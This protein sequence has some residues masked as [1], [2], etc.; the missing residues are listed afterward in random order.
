[1][2]DPEQVADR[3]IGH[4]R[5]LID[6]DPE[7]LRQDIVLRL[8]QEQERIDAA[9]SPEDYAQLVAR[10]ALI[11]GLR[12]TAQEQARRDDMAE[13][14][15]RARRMRGRMARGELSCLTQDMGGVDNA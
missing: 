13:A 9:D 6:D 3:A 5:H 15:A 14:G 8:L 11:D 2:V 1:M 7:D 12:G 4:L 10:N